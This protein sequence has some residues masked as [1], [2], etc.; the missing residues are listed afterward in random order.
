M[1]RMSGKGQR[2]RF[3]QTAL[4]SAAACYGWAGSGLVRGV[5][6]QSARASVNSV[7]VRGD[8]VQITGAGG[9]CVV[10]RSDGGTT[11]V[12]SGAPQAS[13]MLVA[14]VADLTANA[15]VDLLFNTHWHLEHTGAN[16]VYGVAG[17][18]IVAHE[19]T[20]LWMGTEY[21][22]D[23]LDR[24]FAPRV[25]EALP[26]DTF[27]SSDPQPIVIDLDGE[28]I[29]YGH[30]REAHT[31]GDIYVFFRAHNVIVAGGAVSAGAY[32]VLDYATGGWI[33]GLIDATE[34]LLEIADDDTLIVPDS[35]PAQR[36]SHLESQHNMLVTVR[37]RVENLMRDGRS[38]AEMIAAG[39]TTEFDAYWGDNRERFV[40]NVYGGLWWQGR[41]TDSL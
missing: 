23:W 10:L 41:L 18:R 28:E 27:Y 4:G 36:R 8:L 14:E 13:A 20:R 25:A 16:E 3:L 38:A 19:N 12:D 30:L 29:E 17:A 21:Y 33:G 15:P 34:T 1:S 22:V 24:T 31:D 37:E 5:V 7:P 9:N 35:G 26:T 32:P 2:R 11:M 39:V 6:A 40:S